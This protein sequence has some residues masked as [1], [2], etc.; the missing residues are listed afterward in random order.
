VRAYRVVCY[1]CQANQKKVRRLS[2]T[3]NIWGYGRINILL[4]KNGK[5]TLPLVLYYLGNDEKTYL[6]KFLEGVK[7]SDGY[8]YCFKRLVD[9]KACNVSGGKTHDCHVIFQKLLP[10]IVR[11]IYC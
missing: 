9:V 10:L 6:C 8:A 1:K 7:M 5:Y 11:S 3:C 2:L 4:I